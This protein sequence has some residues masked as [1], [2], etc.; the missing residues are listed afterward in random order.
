MHCKR[1]ACLV[2][3][4]CTASSSP[5]CRLGWYLDP[6]LYQIHIQ[7]GGFAATL[8]RWIR[9]AGKLLFLRS[10]TAPVSGEARISLYGLAAVL[11]K[12][13]ARV[14]STCFVILLVLTGTVPVFKSASQPWHSS[15]F[16]SWQIFVQYLPCGSSCF[17]QGPL[18]QQ[19]HSLVFFIN[20]ECCWVPTSTAVQHCANGEAKRSNTNGLIPDLAVNHIAYCA[21]F[22]ETPVE[23]PQRF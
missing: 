4:Y 3:G 11:L 22:L 7:P 2:S 23:S 12:P 20:Y 5:K 19:L 18:R 8:V 21:I 6:R 14:F 10:K 15:P 16:P 13:Y 17:T 9:R 1:L